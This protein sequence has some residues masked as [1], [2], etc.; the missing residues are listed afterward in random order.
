LFTN[1]Y[2]AT[3]CG[4]LITSDCIGG[5]EEC[6][7][8]RPTNAHSSERFLPSHRRGKCQYFKPDTGLP[9]I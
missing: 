9:A 3:S 1:M 4:S 5:F 2:R 8:M 6:Q 7:G